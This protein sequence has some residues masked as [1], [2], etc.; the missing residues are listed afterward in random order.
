M[1]NSVR[2]YPSMLGIEAGFVT[3]F[4]ASWGGR[5]FE[6][7]IGGGDYRAFSIGEGTKAGKETRKPYFFKSVVIA[8]ELASGDHAPARVCLRSRCLKYLGLHSLSGVL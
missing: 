6:V 2:L 3:D 4:S 7:D 1:G 8:G 5:A